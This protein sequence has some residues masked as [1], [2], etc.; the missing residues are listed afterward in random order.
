MD[1][2]VQI[3]IVLSAVY[4]LYVFFCN[5]SNEQK[6]HVHTGPI[7]FTFYHLPNCGWCKRFMPEWERLTAAYRG[8]VALRLVDASSN[9][10]EALELGIDKYPTF[11][12]AAEGDDNIVEYRGPRT[13]QDMARF[14]SQI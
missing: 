9:V 12:L 6:S 13:A 5:A 8:P 7:T 10:E 1:V 14:L 4:V 11:L 2:F 3:V